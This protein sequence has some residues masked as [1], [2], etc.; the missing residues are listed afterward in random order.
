MDRP[1]CES[2]AT[3]DNL[4]IAVSPERRDFTTVVRG[5]KVCMSQIAMKESDDEQ[6]THKLL[7]DRQT[8]CYT[9]ARTGQDAKRHDVEV[10]PPGVTCSDWDCTLEGERDQPAVRLGLRLVG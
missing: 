3:S 1:D 7:H 9:A 8:D 4:P 10:Q 6:W 5:Q 2:R